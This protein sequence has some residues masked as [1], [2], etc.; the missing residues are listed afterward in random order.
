MC[1]MQIEHESKPKRRVECI[2]IRICAC[3]LR[4]SKE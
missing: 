2:P 1:I 4:N 3:A